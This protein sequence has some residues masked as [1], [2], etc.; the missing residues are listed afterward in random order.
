M[1][2]Y[3]RCSLLCIPHTHTFS[4]WATLY[5]THTAS[6]CTTVCTTHTTSIPSTH[7][8]NHSPLMPSFLQPVKDHLQLPVDLPMLALGHHVVVVVPEVSCRIHHYPRLSQLLAD[9]RGSQ[10]TVHRL[11]VYIHNPGS[12]SY[13]VRHVLGL[14][15]HVPFRLLTGVLG[16][17]RLI[18]QFNFFSP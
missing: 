4:K 13:P 2:R 16:W 14:L 7:L 8:C 6:K 17:D 5:I 3:S 10:E 12:I 18:I 11:L 9:S 1:E 15:R